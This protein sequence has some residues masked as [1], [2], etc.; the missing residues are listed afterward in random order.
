MHTARLAKGPSNKKTIMGERIRR[1]Y[2]EYHG[3]LIPDLESCASHLRRGKRGVIWLV[4]D[5][6]MDN[7]YWISNQRV[8]A[9]NGYEDVLEPPKERT[10][11]SPRSGRA[12]AQ[13]ADELEPKERTR[14]SSRRL[15]PPERT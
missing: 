6:T 10:C 2:D 9:C 11:S 14:G 8:P 15:D 12:R 13:G 3:H 7:K 1:F 4:G 5:S